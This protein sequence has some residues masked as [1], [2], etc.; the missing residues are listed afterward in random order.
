MRRAG[1]RAAPVRIARDAAPEI[2][3]LLGQRRLVDAGLAY[4]RT[5]AAY[6][7]GLPLFADYQNLTG[8]AS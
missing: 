2:S 3:L 1:G 7:F 6:N 5:L 4:R 8:L